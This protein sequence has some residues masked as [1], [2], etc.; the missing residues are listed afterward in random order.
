MSHFYPLVDLFSSM[1]DVSKQELEEEHGVRVLGYTWEWEES[2]GDGYGRAASLTP[3]EPRKI[4][5]N[6][7]DDKEITEISP[8]VG[9]HEVKEAFE[10]GRF[11]FDTTS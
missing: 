4:R 10:E 7:S 5:E 1:S 8:I 2:D 9:F 3:E 6:L 11:E